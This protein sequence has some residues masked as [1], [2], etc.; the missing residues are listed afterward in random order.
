MGWEMMPVAKIPMTFEEWCEQQADD[1][2]GYF[3]EDIWKAGRAA[4]LEE[5]AKVA[6]DYADGSL[7]DS[8]SSKDEHR[9]DMLEG[10]SY[11]A[12]KIAASIRALNKGAGGR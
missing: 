12:G 5:A 7:R 11:A 4:G 9:S 10:Q 8:D 6:R 1:P 3:E 2:G